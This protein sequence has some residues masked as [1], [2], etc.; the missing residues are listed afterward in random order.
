MVFDIQEEGHKVEFLKSLLEKHLNTY[1]DHLERYYHVR[2]AVLL[3]KEMRDQ[4]LTTVFG[5]Q[6]MAPEHYNTICHG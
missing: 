4:L 5:D 1:L 3:I 2:P 6:A